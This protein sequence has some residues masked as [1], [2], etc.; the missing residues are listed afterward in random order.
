MRLYPLCA[1]LTLTLALGSACDSGDGA[2]PIT[3]RPGGSSGSGGAGGSGG[4]GSK[5]PEVLAQVPQQAK[6]PSAGLSAPVEAVRD[7]AGVPHIYAE[8]AAD[9]AFAQGYLAANDRFVQMDVFRRN[10]SGTL[11][12]VFG[13]SALANDIDIRLHHLRAT[14]EKSW[15]ALQASADPADREIVRVMGAYAAGVNAWIDELKAGQHALPEALALFY[16]PKFVAP[17]SEID[18]LAIGELQ[19]FGLSFDYDADL[20]RTLAAEREKAVFANAPDAARR[21]R[22]GFV[23]DLT[24]FRPLSPVYTVS[25]WGEVGG[26][27]RPDAPGARRPA[28]APPLR[29]PEPDQGLI[30]LIGRV[31]PAAGGLPAFGPGERGSNNWVVSGALSKSGHVMVANDTH[32]SLTNPS[33][34][35]LVHLNALD[36]LDVMGV[37][38]P[39]IPFV[40]LGFNQRV[41]WG[42]T[43]SQVDVTDL[44]DEAVSSCAADAAKLC[45]AFKGGEVPVVTREESFVVSVANDPSGAITRKVNFY[46]VP[47]HG[48]ILP[49]LVDGPGGPTTAPP[50]GRALSVRYTGYEGYPIFRAVN[51]VVRAKNVAE[52]VAAIEQHFAYGRQNWVFGDVEGNIGWTQASRLPRRPADSKP[53]LVLPGDGSAEWQGVIDPKKIPH[54][55]NPAKGYL[56]TANAD[57]L[58][59]TAT[60][61]PMAQPAA[62]GYPLYI[63]SDYDPGTRVSRI[64]ARITEA[65]AG[66]GK[67]DPEAMASIQAD[68]ITEFGAALRPHF[69]AAAEALAA[70]V[71][72]P[73]ANPELAGVVS[74]RA[75]VRGFY[76]AAAKLVKD[77]SLDTPS[78]FEPG[79]AA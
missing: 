71:A 64:T 66:G 3:L 75:D 29:A 39:G 27:A 22:E 24:D 30:D 21:D 78:G 34:F 73:A 49:T 5:L 9:A 17:W 70:H 1:T 26:E 36:G 38:F 4:G 60:N 16:T 51:A 44:Y 31:R 12:E 65:T 54:A 53:W 2:D 8:T 14:A 76:A 19:A 57:P 46:D 55:I 40:I 74:P 72:D 20:L 7:E 6:V 63:G 28:L 56:V 23:S 61:E 18:S 11:S 15:A 10:A 48:P 47:H 35:Y 58:G 79:L 33:L 25:G 43:V 69:V 68:A 42:A 37:Q 62:D 67:L 52:S 45:V 13:A 50:Q 59:L 32:L 77:W 41:A